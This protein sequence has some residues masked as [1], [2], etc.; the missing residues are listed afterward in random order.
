METR[1]RGYNNP[2]IILHNII[3]ISVQIYVI[4]KLR[5]MFLSIIVGAR[6]WTVFMSAAPP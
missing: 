5:F 1:V 6:E 4:K 3:D 2:A